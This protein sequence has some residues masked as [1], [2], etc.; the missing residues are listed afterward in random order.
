MS[1]PG[2]HV[3]V[4]TLIVMLASVAGNRAHAYEIFKWVDENGVV[5]FSESRPEAAP[6]PVEKLYIP[7]TNPPGYDASEDYWSVL[8]QAARIGEQWMALEKELE[9]EEARERALAAEQR[10]AELERRLAAAE[11]AAYAARPVYAPFARFP[12][13]RHRFLDD[14]FEGFAHRFPDRRTPPRRRDT[15]PRPGWPGPGETRAPAVPRFA[16]PAGR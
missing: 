1:R 9:E 13:H 4:C 10:A 3:P 8:N 5:H 6:A 14:R 2:R 11:D 7:A 16:P 15:G 12:S